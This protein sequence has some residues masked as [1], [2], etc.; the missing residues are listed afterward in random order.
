MEGTIATT[1]ARQ[2]MTPD[3]LG[4]VPTAPL[5]V[6]LKMMVE[7][8]VRHLPVVDNGL[9]VGLLHEADILWHLWST[10]G[11]TSAP[12]AVVARP[13]RP[14]VSAQ[15]TAATVARSMTRASS[16]VVLVLDEGRIE[17]IVTATNLVRLLGA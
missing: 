14:C 15:D 4:I 1:P 2:L 11:R 5:E 3:V 8:R 17:G 13:P 12:C 9:C 6:A 10:N 7:A 16:D